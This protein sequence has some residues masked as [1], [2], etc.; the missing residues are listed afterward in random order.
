MNAMLALLKTY[1]QGGGLTFQFNVLNA[2]ALKDAQIHPEKYQTLQIRVCG[3]NT[4]WNN[5]PKSE[6]DK[7][8]EQ[9]EN[10]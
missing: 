6:Q 1:N 5:M 8:I 10:I 9:A 4:L 2:D 3:W 7:Y